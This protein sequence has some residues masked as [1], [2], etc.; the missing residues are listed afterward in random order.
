M[1]GSKRLHKCPWYSFDLFAPLSPPT[2]IIAVDDFSLSCFITAYFLFLRCISL[3]HLSVFF[4]IEFYEWLFWDSKMISYEKLL[5][6][7]HQN[8]F[9]YSIRVSS[10]FPTLLGYGS[11]FLSHPSDTFKFNGLLHPKRFQK[12][13]LLTLL[14]KSWWRV[15]HS[16]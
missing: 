2:F 4:T 8:G 6:F 13:Q 5:V 16:T 10:T 7:S 1:C 15:G 9:F 14:V 12:T 11:N 3:L